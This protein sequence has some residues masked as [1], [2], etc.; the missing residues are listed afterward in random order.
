MKTK[1]VWLYIVIG[2]ALSLSVLCSVLASLV[3]N[4]VI[5][6]L[7]SSVNWI[8]ALTSFIIAI[9]QYRQNS[10]T[11]A[12]QY[13]MDLY[14]QFSNDKDLMAIYQ[15][16]DNDEAIDCVKY[17]Y[18]IIHYLAYFDSIY[19]LL[20]RNI[21]FIDDVDDTFSYYVFVVANNASIQDNILY[22]APSYYSKC[23]L[24]CEALRK[25]RDKKGLCRI[26]QRELRSSVQAVD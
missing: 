4:K 2:L 18:D 14:F 12:T 22:A 21:I 13:L 10:L 11:S 25:Y 6:A 3:E 24:L 17:R 1:K 15:M 26:G 5:S 19:L 16:A 23:F 8:I 20:E 7:L 9:I